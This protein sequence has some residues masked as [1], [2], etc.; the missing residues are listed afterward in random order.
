LHLGSRI[1]DQI[2]SKHLARGTSES[3]Q[4]MMD[5]SYDIMRTVAIVD[6]IRRPR[7]QRTKACVPSCNW[8]S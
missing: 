3:G 5:S 7:T 2:T 6:P 4:L 8:H 1:V